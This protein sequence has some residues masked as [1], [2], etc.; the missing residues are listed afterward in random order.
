M[1][2]FPADSRQALRLRRSLMAGGAAFVLSVLVWIAGE[3]RLVRLQQSQIAWLL[4]AFWI[5]NFVF[6]A[7]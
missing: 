6:F 5:V 7:V 3:Y 2:F 1:T 4:V